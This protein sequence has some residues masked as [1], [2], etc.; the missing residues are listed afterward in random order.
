MRLD[1]FGSQ[2][3]YQDHIAPV[4]W[5]LP[6]EARGH[7]YVTGILA[8]EGNTEAIPSWRI[9]VPPPAAGLPV[10]VAGWTDESQLG[11]RPAIYLE[12]GAGQTYIEPHESYSGSAGHDNV[13]LFLCPSETVADRWRA[14][15]PRA[16]VAVVGC[17]KLDVW[18]R[19]LVV[20]R[21]WKGVEPRTV[22][23]TFHSD[24]RHNSETL[25]SLPHY[26]PGLRAAVHDLQAGGWRVLG[27]GHP[28][29]WAR[30]SRVWPDLG[31]ECVRSFDDV[32]A[33]ASVLCVD[34]SSAGPEFASTGRPLVWMNAPWYRRDVD[35]GGRFWQWP[36]DQ[37]T[38]DHADQLAEAVTRAAEDPP[39]AAESRAAMV[40]AVYAFRDGRAAERAAAAI[41]GL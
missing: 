30:I 31:V 27:H 21:T 5:A 34:N 22:A 28:R 16:R 12:H 24:A 33:R 36:R 10:L 38:I 8:E 39:E 1:G 4:W 29:I 19:R 17:P 2:R 41:L 7:F 25:S 32:L 37:V 3:Q 14:R 26:E 18:H 15:Y 20:D 9:G 23:I 35:H 11:R 40:D 6:P 13:R